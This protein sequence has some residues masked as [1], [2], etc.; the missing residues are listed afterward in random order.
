M[1]GRAFQVAGTRPRA[2]GATGHIVLVR[3][4]TSVA[5]V[6]NNDTL[7]IP[8]PPPPAS[9]QL[10]IGS[11]E[12]STEQA[13]SNNGA[14]SNAPYAFRL[15]GVAANAGAPSG[16]IRIHLI[17]SAPGRDP[18]LLQGLADL[19]VIRSDPNLLGTPID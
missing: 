3:E 8:N 11:L 6:A 7:T 15:G 17:E 19:H 12:L 9:A 16:F 14:V 13:S 18:D 2:K 4:L 1:S 5:P 10:T